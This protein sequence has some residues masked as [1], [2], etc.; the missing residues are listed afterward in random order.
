MAKFN[1]AWL[2]RK[3]QFR[4]LTGVDIDT[5]YVMTGRLLPH[6][7]KRVVAP[8]NRAG[9]P[10][11]VGGLEDHLLV[12]LILYRCAVSQDFLACL[13]QVDKSAICRALR[14]I[15]PLA[16]CVLGVKRTI[17]VSAEEAEALIID[18]TE[19]PIQRPSRKQRCWYSGKKKGHRIKNEIIVTEKGKIVSASDSTP[20]RVSDITVRRR[21]PPLPKGARAY[22][23]SGYQGLQDEHPDIDIPYKKSKHHPLTRDEKDYNHGLSRFRVRVE[24]KIAQI[25]RFRILSDRFRYPRSSHAAKFAITAGIVNL[26]SGF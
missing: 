11:G 14:R 8:K 5:F 12:L 20:G 25:K 6:W 23:D 15:E 22:A 9:R 18:A 3:R 10:W 19:Q 7:N 24:H 13:Y 4:A 17:R 26:L 2:T 21:G 16:R 1:A